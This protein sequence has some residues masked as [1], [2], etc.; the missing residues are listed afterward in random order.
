MLKLAGVL[1]AV[2]YG[3][4][5]FTV[6]SMSGA[7]KS[8]VGQDGRPRG[9]V[10]TSARETKLSLPGF[11]T[12]TAFNGGWH[13]PVHLAS[14]GRDVGPDSIVAVGTN[15]QRANRWAKRLMTWGNL[16]APQYEDGSDFWGKNVGCGRGQP[17]LK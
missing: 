14:I 3:S 17:T 13:G 1:L 8:G 7:A 4:C 11:D 12:K 9:L 16:P 2:L 5:G 6:A 15:D 10:R